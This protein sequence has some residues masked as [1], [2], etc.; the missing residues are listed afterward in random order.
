MNPLVLLNNLKLRNKLAVM[1]LAP[2][3][4][5]LFFSGIQIQSRSA[6]VTE[7]GRVEDLADLNARLNGAVHEL[8]RERGRSSLFAGSGGK[9]YGAELAEQ[10]R[11]TDTALASTS[12]YLTLFKAAEYG[13]TFKTELDTV[14]KQINDLPAHRQAIDALSIPAKEITGFYTTTINAMLT[15]NGHIATASS[16][17]EIAR[18]VTTNNAF[19]QAKEATGLERATLSNVLARGSYDVGQYVQFVTLIASQS[20]YLKVFQASATPEQVEAYKQTVQGGSVDAVARMEQLALDQATATAITGIDA[21]D[22]FSQITAKIDLQ[23]QIEH[24]LSTAVVVR[25]QQLGSEARSEQT[26]AIATGLLALILAVGCAL[27][28]ARSISRPLAAMTDAADG[29]AVGDIDQRVEIERGDEIGRMAAAFRR[30]IAYQRRMADAAGSIAE[31]DLTRDVKPACQRDVLGS[32]F[33]AMTTSLRGLVQHVQ[34]SATSLAQTAGQLGESA[35]QSG[36]AVEQVT[37]A[38]QETAARAQDTTTET[39]STTVAVEQLAQAIDNIARGATEQ[40]RQ[41]QSA[42]AVTASMASEVAQVA[43]TAEAVASVSERARESAQQGAQAVRETVEGMAHITEV[44]GDAAGKVKDLGALGERIGVVVETIN[45]IAEQTNLLALNAAIEAARAGEHG[46]GF[47]VV[48]D[49]VRKLAERS[50]RETRS[51]AQLIADVQLG[52]R[53]AVAAIEG[54]AAQVAAGSALADQAG[55]ALNE[56]VGAAGDAAGRVSEIATVSRQIAAGAGSVVEAMDRINAVAGQSASAAEQMAAQAVQVNAAVRSIADLSEENSA[57]MEEVSAAAE[58]MSAQAEET[59]AQ[60]EEVAATAETL[61]AVV[62][63]FKIDAGDTGGW[64]DQERSQVRLA[65]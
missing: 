13:A 64:Q 45:D 32:A 59:A 6:A 1:L 30:M 26:T 18:L 28:V 17:P 3:L 39:R 19:S 54:T 12:E 9:S 35:A 16:D 23:K 8:Q 48:A 2:L 51:I 5:L 34:S 4:G 62:S 52:A 61:Q 55:M 38:V 56:I 27:V 42:S 29:L 37:L 53:D 7:L 36:G 20:T 58:Q 49:E 44:V 25:A 46:R 60:A 14:V 15:V 57:S 43:Q 41:V 10:R 21:N 24:Q 33:A 22:W 40:A 50:Q 31:G 65:A 47:A 11:V 63:R